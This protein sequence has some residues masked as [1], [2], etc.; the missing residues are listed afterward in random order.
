MRLTKATTKL[1]GLLIR[2]WQNIENIETCFSAHIYWLANSTYFEYKLRI[3]S[4]MGLNPVANPPMPG[5]IPGTPGCTKP[6][7]VVIPGIPGIVPGGIIPP[8]VPIPGPIPIGAI[9]GAA[10]I[11]GVPKPGI[12]SSGDPTSNGRFISCWACFSSLFSLS[13]FILWTVSTLKLSYLTSWIM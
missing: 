7:I 13:S 10:I 8:I 12:T 9:T 3:I 2:Q 11:I 4:H 1:T 6:D 5:A